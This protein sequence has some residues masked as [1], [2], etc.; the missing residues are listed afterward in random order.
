MSA[1][2]SRSL[3]RAMNRSRYAIV[4]VMVL[5]GLTGCG[6]EQS[7]TVPSTPATEASG[8]ADFEPAKQAGY[9]IIGDVDSVRYPTATA[10]LSIVLRDIDRRP[11]QIREMAAVAAVQYVTELQRRGVIATG[12]TS[13]LVAR[14]TRRFDGFRQIWHGSGTRLARQIARDP[15]VGAD[16][17]AQVAEL[18]SR[19]RSVPETQTSVVGSGTTSTPSPPVTSTPSTTGGASTPSTTGGASTPRPST[20]KTCYPRVTVPAVHIGATHIPA[21]TIPAKKIG[22]T[23][24]PAVHLPATNLPAIT[25]PATTIHG[26]CLDVPRAFALPNTTV[27]TENYSAIDSNYSPK[28]P[29][30]DWDADPQGTSTPDPTASGFGTT[31]DAGFPRDQY[32]RPYVRRDGTPVAGYWRNSPTDGLPTCDVITC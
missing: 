31:N 8:S 6:N 12:T 24:Y 5:L 29:A 18:R 2:R 14:L 19:S 4:A 30:Q 17:Q 22:G 32:V 15:V 9:S 21:E 13:D 10:V 20:T 27:R 23:T 1:P 25:L 16:L 28:L 3:D 26:G 7:R 11:R